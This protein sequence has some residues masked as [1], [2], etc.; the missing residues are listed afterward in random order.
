MGA[1]L[2]YYKTPYGASNCIMTVGEKFNL[3]EAY[4]AIADNVNKNNTVAQVSPTEI[5][6]VNMIKLA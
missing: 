6:I 4:R 2:V 5:V 3:D 1:W